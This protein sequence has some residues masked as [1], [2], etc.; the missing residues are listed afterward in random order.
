MAT[1]WSDWD[2]KGEDRTSMSVFITVVLAF[3]GK[4]LSD[5]FWMAIFI[6][7]PWLLSNIQ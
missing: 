1:R 3:M 6:I 4:W 2:M 5:M 7:Q